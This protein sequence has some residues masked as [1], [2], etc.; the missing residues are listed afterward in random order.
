MWQAIAASVAGSVLDKIM[1]HNADSDAQDMLEQAAGHADEDR[2]KQIGL[3]D[4]FWR[5]LLNRYTGFENPSLKTAIALGKKYTA[6]SQV[7]YDAAVGRFV[8]GDKYS[9]DR[10]RGLLQ[11]KAMAG[12]D[13][14]YDGT[15]NAA[16]MQAHRGS[17]SAGPII[18]ALT[19]Q[20][21][22]D[23]S[24]ALRDAELA[25]ITGAEGLNSQRYKDSTAGLQAAGNQRTA[26]MSS[27]LDDASKYGLQAGNDMLGIGA[28]GMFSTLNN[29]Y[30]TASKIKS[31]LY[32]QRAK[33]RTETSKGDGFFGGLGGSLG[34]MFGGK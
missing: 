16:V 33:Q 29:A 27:A 6:E 24:A 22:K 15:T 18:A 13:D 9:A 21:A 11:Q 32:S 8:E 31:A 1:S 12:L 19:K 17:T 4:D 34:G 28:K 2:D 23:S 20:R 30:D 5:Q 7:P 25:A 3:G 26:M 10:L 14:A